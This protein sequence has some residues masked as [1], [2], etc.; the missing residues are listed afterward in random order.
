M[1]RRK[2]PPE[3]TAL[4]NA[5]EDFLKKEI[6]PEVKGYSKFRTHVAINLLKV[7]SRET[8]SSNLDAKVEPKSM[9]LQLRSGEVSWSDP[10]ALQ[11][12][13]TINIHALEIDN[14]H[15]IRK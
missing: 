11:I 4:L 15:W 7:I 13:K 9:A 14:P 3:T 2:L 10:E 12:V 5:I 8:M 6:L 1:N